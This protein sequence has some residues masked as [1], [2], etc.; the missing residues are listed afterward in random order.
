MSA[1][2]LFLVVITGL[3]PSVTV[4]RYQPSEILRGDFRLSGHRR[5]SKILLS[6]QFLIAFVTVASSFLLTY[7][8]SR[9]LEADWGYEPENLIGAR[10]ISSEQTKLLTDY[11]QS[12]QGVERITVSKSHISVHDYRSLIKYEEVDHEV[13]SYF[14]DY[15]Y[16]QTL[17]LRMQKGRWFD[18]IKSDQMRSAVI[19]QAMAE[20]VIEGDPLGKTIKLQGKPLTIVGITDN[21]NYNSPFRAVR[22]T[23]FL[24]FDHEVEHPLQYVT[25]KTT[26]QRK[27]EIAMAME[28]FMRT[29]IPDEPYVSYVQSEVFSSTYRDQVAAIKV[30][31][32][33]GTLAV[34]LS[35]LGLYGLLSYHILQKRRVIS[36]RKIV[37]ATNYQIFGVVSRGYLLS[38]AAAI[39][40]GVPLGY[41]FVDSLL[42]LL[43]ENYVIPAIGT[44]AAVIVMVLGAIWITV[45]FKI[46]EINRINPADNLRV[47]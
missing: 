40:M 8:Y 39:L 27:E 35:C 29:Q 7:N 44:F 19:N 38:I 1:F 33:I 43:Y 9:V 46:R 30:F 47:E 2:L 18:S 21:F 41:F 45:L 31:S 20:K 15:N 26:E 17:G 22:P 11:L 37:G 13:V 23:I 28:D 34:I 4:S 3:Y 14:V 6:S 10:T 36:I 5:L 32:F 12:L 24:G 42:N 16:F 25:V